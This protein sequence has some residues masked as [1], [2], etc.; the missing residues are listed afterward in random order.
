MLTEVS[1][2]LGR[3]RASILKVLRSACTS[4]ISNE[5][6]Q[7]GDRDLGHSL[8]L[9]VQGPP[10]TIGRD[11]LRGSPRRSHH[12]SGEEQFLLKMRIEIA[13]DCWRM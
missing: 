10:T 9:L 4:G 1:Y 5:S 7:R 3:T 11:E 2:L 6:K 12:G 13:Q 8:C